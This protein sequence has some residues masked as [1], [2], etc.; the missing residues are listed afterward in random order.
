MSGAVF[1]QK[2][3]VVDAQDLRRA[4][5]EQ[6]VLGLDAVLL[7][8]ELGDFGGRGELIAPDLAEAARARRRA[9]RVPGPAGS[10]CWPG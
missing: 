5:T 10:R 1:E 9:P 7:G 2:T 3:C 8:D 4:R 6:H